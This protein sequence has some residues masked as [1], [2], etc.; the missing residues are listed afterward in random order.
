MSARGLIGYLSIILAGVLRLSAQPTIIEY[1]IPTAG[2]DA[3]AITSGPDGN[4]WFTENGGNHIGRI[5]TS[6]LITEYGVTSPEGI[7]NGPDSNLW[8]VSFSAIVGKIS[9]SGVVMLNDQ[10]SATV[11]YFIT[12][13]SDG[14]LWFTATSPPIAEVVRLTVGCATTGFSFTGLAYHIATGPDGNLWFTEPMEPNDRIGKITTSGAITHYAMAPDTRALDIAAGPDGNLWFTDDFTSSVGRITTNGAITEFPTST[15]LS[16]PAGI[17]RG[18][19]G[20]MWFTEGFF[21]SGGNNVGKVILAPSVSPTPA[22][23]A[24]LLAILGFIALAGWKMLV[25][26]RKARASGTVEALTRKSTFGPTN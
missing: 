16:R 13:G 6:G 7:T 9:P 15:A 5:T 22:P 26:A 17:T 25:S 21:V 3:E 24:G 1:P 14:N 4:L 8:F 10:Y 2:S 12:S 11:G 23:S 20:N 19:D 18:P